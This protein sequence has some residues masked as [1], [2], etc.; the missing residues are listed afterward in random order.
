MAIARINR[1]KVENYSEDILKRATEKSIEGNN[2]LQQAA[3][4]SPNGELLSL[5]LN[6]FEESI[7]IYSRFPDPYIGVSWLFHISGDTKVAISFIL[8]ALE[9][10]PQNPI[11]LELLDKYHQGLKSETISQAANKAID[12]IKPSPLPGENDFSAGSDNIIKNKPNLI[13]KLNYQQQKTNA[14]QKFLNAYKK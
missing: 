12:R 4:I 13:E 3:K 2:Y 14:A 5:A 9:I 8:N 1:L 7:S 11:A 10:D 6:C